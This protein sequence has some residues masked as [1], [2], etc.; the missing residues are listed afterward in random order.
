MLHTHK[1]LRKYLSTAAPQLP[2]SGLWE[3]LLEKSQTTYIKHRDWQ[4][5]GHF[6]DKSVAN[7]LCIM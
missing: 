4:F 3:K 1:Q 5:S 6:M 2:Q 7:V